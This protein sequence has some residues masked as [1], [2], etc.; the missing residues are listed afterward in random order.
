MDY[1]SICN[2]VHKNTFVFDFRPRL[3]VSSVFGTSKI[4]RVPPQ[5]EKF[6]KNVGLLIQ[7]AQ[8]RSFDALNATQKN[9]SSLQRTVSKKKDKMPKNKLFSKI[10][11]FGRFFLI[12]PETVVF[13]ELRLFLLHLVHQNLSFVLSKSIIQQFFRFFTIRGDTFDLTQPKN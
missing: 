3:G 7:I 8:K 10:T 1:G 4:K 9:I 12:V 2:S 5:G 11:F 13:R 6:K